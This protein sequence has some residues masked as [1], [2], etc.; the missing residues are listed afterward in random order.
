VRWL[1]AGGPLHVQNKNQFDAYCAFMLHFYWLLCT[2]AFANHIA[3]ARAVRGALLFGSLPL[4]VQVY[5][6]YTGGGFDSTEC[7]ALAFC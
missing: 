6:Y 2:S 7:A 5:V 4:A 1:F 3:G